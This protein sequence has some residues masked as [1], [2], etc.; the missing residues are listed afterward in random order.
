M[1]HLIQGGGGLRLLVEESGRPES[2]PIL[3][4]HGFSQCRLAWRRQVE[5]ALARSF[6]LVCLDLRGHGR[7]DKPEEPALY[8]DGKLWADDIAAVIGALGLA[9]P[10][11]VG[12]SYGGFVIADYLRHHGEEQIGGLTLVAAV[13]KFGD[14]EAAALY[15]T[16]I[17]RLMPE[18][19]VSDLSAALPAL[20]RFLRLMTQAELPEP[21]VYTILGWMVIVPPQIRQAMFNRRLDNDDILRAITVPVLVTQGLADRIVLPA[22]SEHSARLIRH[23]ETSFYPE[24]GHMSFRETTDQFNADLAGFAER[25]RAWWQ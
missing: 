21:E 2:P 11:L 6:R 25:C 17:Q 10:V 14:S 19:F 23:A 7:S 24:V 8:R 15:G 4:I 1:Q 16:E 3:F 18:F 13:T 9:R 12:W 22:M 20:Q 5:S